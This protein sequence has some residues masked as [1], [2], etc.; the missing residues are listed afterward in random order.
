M[1]NHFYAAITLQLCIW[2]ISL[3]GVWIY[4][5]ESQPIPLI[6][7]LLVGGLVSVMNAV[8]VMIDIPYIN[9]FIKSG[10]TNKQ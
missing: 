1:S 4:W 7:G 9:P 6:V 8:F 5:K 3:I 10:D 2:V